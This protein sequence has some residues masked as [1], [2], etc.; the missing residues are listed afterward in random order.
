MITHYNVNNSDLKEISKICAQNNIA[1]IE[2]CAIS[3]G[4][5]L[6]DD[7]VGKIG[8]FAIFSFGFYKFVNVLSGGM[9]ISKN[10]EFYEY[11][12]ETEKNW[13]EI[14]FYNLYKL[15]IKNFLI[16][17]LST[18]IIFNLIFPII[19]IAYK[20]NLNSITKFFINDPK[21]HIKN[22]F[23]KE[24]KFRLSKIQIYDIIFQLDELENQR[25]VRQKNYLSY[26]RNI[27][28]TEV[29]FF[30]N[31]IDLLCKNAY[32]NFPILVKNKTNFINYMLKNG[33]DLSPQ[34]YR[35]VNQLS[36]FS[37][38]SDFTKETNV[39]VKKLVTLPTYP[40]INQK[41]ILKVI[42]VINRYKP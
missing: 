22:N 32:L 41:Y 6:N 37:D 30:H 3:I 14:K 9:V 42:E 40:G 5:K 10:N 16:R 21:P 20:F 38:F 17:F 18:K 8:D 39:S 24:Y 13:R 28:N 23:P 25:I 15:I 27:K 19:K 26:S 34:F 11:L 1:L 4:S 2:D 7:Y 33:I 12:I 36:I 35:S 31:E 29:V